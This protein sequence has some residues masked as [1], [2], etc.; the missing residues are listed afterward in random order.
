MIFALAT[1]PSCFCK[2]LQWI[3]WLAC[4][5][6]NIWHVQAVGMVDNQSTEQN[7]VSQFLSNILLPYETLY[8]D[9]ASQEFA[10]YR[11]FAGLL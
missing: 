8:C 11:S 6:E 10:V 1:L 7:Q 4:K 9:L 3:H 2:K 5:G